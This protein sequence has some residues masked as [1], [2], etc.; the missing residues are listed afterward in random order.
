MADESHVTK[1]IDDIKRQVIA[2]LDEARTALIGLNTVEALFGVPMTTLA[3]LAALPSGTVPAATNGPTVQ[4]GTFGRRSGPVRADEFL[5]MEPMEAAKAYLRRVGQATDFDEIAN[6]VATGGAV[7][8]GA[9]WRDRLETSLMRSSKGIIK[10][11]EKTYGLEDF[12]S[13]EQIRRIRQSRRASRGER[14]KKKPAK[15]KGSAP[16]ATAAKPT[17]EGGTKPDE[18]AK[19]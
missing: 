13:E 2:R 14:K 12:Y 10:I 5:G 19:E 18:S 1:T 17:K 6:A 15:A 4:S 16:K 7:V 11:G 9:G 3:D 8:Q